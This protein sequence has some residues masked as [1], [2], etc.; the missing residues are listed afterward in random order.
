MVKTL[1]KAYT[2]STVGIEKRYLDEGGVMSAEVSA[3][4]RNVAGVF[5]LLFFKSLG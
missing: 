4:F 3:Q 5:Y 2:L 1:T